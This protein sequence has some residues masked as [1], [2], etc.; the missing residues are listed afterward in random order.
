MKID[1]TYNG[2]LLTWRGRDYK[3]TSGLPGTQNETHQCV[4]DKGPV[5][6]GLYK[7]FINDQGMAADDGT[8]SCNLKPSWG[9]QTIPRGAKAGECEPFW[10]NWGKNRARLEAAASA[11][12]KHCAPLAV[13][14][15]ICTTPLRVIAMGALK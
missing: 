9:M 5:P 4:P 15:F 7:L 11:T 14:G 3:A 6:E 12:K 10:A 8:G 1:M 2:T 13:V